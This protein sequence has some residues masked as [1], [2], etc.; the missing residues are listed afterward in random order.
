M[1]PGG[2]LPGPTVIFQLNISVI[3]T[4]PTVKTQWW[5]NVSDVDKSRT[6]SDIFRKFVNHCRGVGGIRTP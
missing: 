4:K 2:C 6:P 1:A 3:K 5:L